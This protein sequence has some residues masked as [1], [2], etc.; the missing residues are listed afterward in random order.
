MTPAVYDTF[1]L[2]GGTI[3]KVVVRSVAEK[4]CDEVIVAD[5]GDELLFNDRVL[6]TTTLTFKK[7]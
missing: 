6:D 7:A 2:L 5:K 1:K 4:T 3:E